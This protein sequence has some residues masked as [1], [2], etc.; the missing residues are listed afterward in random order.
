[1]SERDGYPQGV[2][3]WTD[4]STSDVEGARAFYGSLFGWEWEVTGP[5][6]G[7]YST[8]RLSGK[9]V[10]AVASR[11]DDS[12]PVAWTTYLAV[13]DID[14]VAAAVP[15]A[16]GT[17]VMQHDIGEQG[18]MGIG[19]DP[20]GAVFGVWQAAAHRGAELVNE[21]GTLV[22]HELVSADLPAAQAFYTAVL[23]VGWGSE[24]MA[25][26]VP[27]GLLQV[28]GRSVGGATGGVPPHWAVYVEVADTDATAARIVELGGR[29]LTPVAP[30]PQ[31]PFGTFADP[32]GGAFAIIASGAADAGL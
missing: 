32:Q 17:W 20:A 13:D 14:A 16:G 10:A 7:N 15:A 19:V 28:G 27:Y 8:A 2:P 30:S 6:F 21:P 5:E 26:G 11:M 29:E 22:W 18:R 9:R 1:M 4:L 25:P 24:E 31:G 3:C 23:G 12:Q